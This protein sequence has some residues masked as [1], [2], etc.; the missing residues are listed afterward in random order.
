MAVFDR[1]QQRLVVRIVYDGPANAGKTTNLA[2][3]CRFFTTL[4]RSEL[5][6]HEERAGRTLFFDWL[7]LDGGL[8]GGHPLRCQ[9]VTV[10]GQAVLGYRRRHLLRK[11]D[12]VV[13]VCESVPAG[14]D[15]GRRMIEGL[16][17]PGG[18]GIPLVVQANKQ[19]VAGCLE[20][21]QVARQ[22]GL[23]PT[24]PVVPARAHEGAGVRETLVLAIRAAANRAQLA[25]LERGLEAM[26]GEAETDEA[27]YRALQH[28]PPPRAGGAS[29]VLAS[30]S[31]SAEIVA[32]PA[33]ART[34]A[35]SLPPED[36]ARTTPPP[37][38]PLG[39]PLPGGDLPIGYVWPA[40]VGREVLRSLR[41][42]QAVRRDDL[43]GRHGT[44]DG[45]GT[46]DAVIYEASGWCLK[47]SRRRRFEDPD[48]GRTAMIQLARR[49]A[50][51]GPL[52]AP[53]TV[54]CLQPEGDGL[55]LWTVCPWVTT[56]RAWMGQAAAGG[57]ETALELAL[58]AYVDA[59]MEALAAAARAHIV[60]DVHPSNF[61]LAEGRIVYLDDDFGTGDSVPAIGHALLRRVDEYARW[62][63][64]VEAYLQALIASI[65]NRLQPEEIQR[66]GLETAVGEALVTSEAAQSGREWLKG[67]IRRLATTPQ[68]LD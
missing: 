6:V 33:Q 58:T 26:S 4:R 9:L 2:Q 52:L 30:L 51:L 56:L 1:Q 36:G 59:A 18:D 39:P 62:P 55:W 67:A 13:F 37:L 64:A 28:E 14:L 43:V 31:P 17:P 34:T 27:L 10:P 29:T 5:V 25:L 7:H 54:L 21:P 49:K 45:S 16:L 48:L 44:S 41:P 53:R 47:T 24:V 68:K 12:A 20:P 63:M 50:A 22:L 32:P 57:D 15:L 42:Q 8:V 23:P 19:D 65:E 60:I 66:L 46:S 40:V 38:A 3:L 61:A 11:A 35:A